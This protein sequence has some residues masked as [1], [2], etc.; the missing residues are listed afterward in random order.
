MVVSKLCNSKNDLDHWVHSKYLPSALFY[1]YNCKEVASAGVLQT[2]DGNP[3][4]LSCNL[5]N[6]KD[7]LFWRTSANTCFCLQA[8]TLHICQKRDSENCLQRFLAKESVE[9]GQLPNSTDLKQKENLKKCWK[10]SC[11]VALFLLKMKTFSRGIH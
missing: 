1:I 5:Q 9:N 10:I 4:K 3:I 6:F 2:C 11:K 7:H 8:P